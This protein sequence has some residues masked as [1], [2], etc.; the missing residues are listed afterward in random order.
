MAPSAQRK[1][2]R[3]WRGQEVAAARLLGGR[4][5]LSQQWRRQQCTAA[6]CAAGVAPGRGASLPAGGRAQAGPTLT[7]PLNTLAC[8]FLRP[9][10]AHPYN[11]D[12]LAAGLR[13]HRAGHVEDA[14]MNVYSFMEQYAQVRRDDAIAPWE[15][16]AR[17]AVCTHGNVPLP[18]TT[19]MGPQPR[20]RREK[21]G[22]GRRARACTVF[23]GPVASR[24]TEPRPLCARPSSRAQPLS[25][26]GGVAA[27]APAASHARAC[28]GV[29]RARSLPSLV[30]AGAF[31][32]FAH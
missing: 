23:A 27:P 12:G 15:K 28:A 20:Q 26:A 9:G 14:H 32:T 29:A 17:E 25:T 4:S 7:S 21:R 18:G 6:R 19:D 24:R 2:G 3:A 13:N 11:K 1:Q 22:G 16:V 8:A 31:D 10:P 5:L 30:Q